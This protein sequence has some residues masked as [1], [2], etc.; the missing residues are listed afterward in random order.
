[1]DS[2]DS[3]N[4]WRMDHHTAGMGDA[5]KSVSNMWKE[6]QGVNLFRPER[7]FSLMQQDSQSGV[8]FKV[9]AKLHNQ[10]V[11]SYIV[12]HNLLNFLYAI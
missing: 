11:L 2:V 10:L 3:A 5:V 8:L 4:E 1:M 12:P 9:A 6:S 7:G